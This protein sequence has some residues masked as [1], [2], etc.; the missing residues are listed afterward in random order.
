MNPNNI[1]NWTPNIEYKAGD[2]IKRR[3]GGLIIKIKKIYYS[4]IEIIYD[5]RENGFSKYKFHEYLCTLGFHWPI[6]WNEYAWPGSTDPPEAPESDWSCSWCGKVKEPYRAIF[7][8]PLKE[9]YYI[10]K[11]SKE[12]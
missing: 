12:K 3:K 8:W 5:I 7:W 1:P 2:R 9:K 11:L 10:H 6:Q 4:N